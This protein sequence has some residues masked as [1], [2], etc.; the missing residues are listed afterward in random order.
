MALTQD[1]NKDRSFRETL[2]YSALVIASAAKQSMP[3][4]ESK[5]Y[6]IATALHARDDGINQHFPKSLRSFGSP[7][8]FHADLHLAFQAKSHRAMPL[9]VVI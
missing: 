1:E 3:H 7:F 6:G 4:K 8:W 5:T 2:I 9:I